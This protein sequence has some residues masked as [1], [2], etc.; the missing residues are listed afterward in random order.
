MTTLI[1]DVEADGFLEE[2]TRLWTIQIGTEDGEDVDVYADQ[3]GYPPLKDGIARLKKADHVVFHNGMKFDIHAINKIY[4]DTLRPE[5]IYDTMV[6]GRLLFPQYKTHS[7]EAW[8]ERLGKS[9]GQYTGDFKSFTKELVIYAKQ[10]IVVT[11]ALWQKLK[12][13]FDAW[14]WMQAFEMECLFQ[15]VI[16]LQEQN[17][18][19]LNISLAVELE[20]ELRQ[21]L[22]D[23][24]IELQDIFPIRVIPDGSIEKSYRK[25][26]SKATTWHGLKRKRDNP[27]L[28]DQ[29]KGEG[30]I[31]SEWC[32]I[33][34]ETF[35]PSS[36]KQ[37]ADRLISKYG[38]KPWKF[39]DTGQPTID[40]D[41]LSELPYPEA[42][43][44]LRYL[45]VEKQLG[46]I[47]NKAG[48][49]GWLIFVNSK[50]HRVHGA[51]NTLGAGT[52]R[53]SHFAP[54]MAQVNKKNL[55]MR[56]CWIPRPGW[57]LVGSDADGLE[58]CCLAHYVHPLD[59]GVT[60]NR[61][62]NGDKSLGTDV[63][64][65]NRDAI[66]ASLAQHG[67]R[68]NEPDKA[69][70]KALREMAKT[71]IYAL[72]YG[73]TDPRL[74]MTMLEILDVLGCKRSKG[75]NTHPK[76]LGEIARKAL[77]KGIPGLDK[78][79][80]DVKKRSNKRGFVK[81]IDGR[82]IFVRSEHSAFNFLLQGAGA[83]A[84]K[85]ALVIFHFEELPKTGWVHGVDFGYCA[86][87]HDEVQIEAKPEI[88]QQIGDLF[89]K[90]INLAGERLGFRCP[91][92][93]TADVGNTWKDTH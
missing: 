45:T 57:K 52:G 72:M 32:R 61:H 39:S 86:N 30:N 75:N 44:M 88:A 48:D 84:M 70:L 34:Y 83:I 80:D 87:V 10:D 79:I 25:K 11:R 12:K 63:H 43:A 38:W 26:E 69:M 58:F 16:G 15:Y 73:A 27:E 68:F 28:W 6:G 21:E 14:S 3:P 8:G 24:S 13:K 55:R 76:K 36:R 54:N 20:A 22:A 37:V 33:T 81:G 35:N 23:I 51:V 1:C 19:M 53:C 64:S 18:F 92:T 41:V 46:Q 49:K 17:G 40:E 91:L 29:V 67:F 85:Q 42:K 31:T 74:G 56:E 93:G 66:L 89:A 65:A 9:K 7:L 5:Q 71:L 77:G 78:L 4:P 47:I 62:I 50:T 82:K 60:A 59:D 90:C 2:M